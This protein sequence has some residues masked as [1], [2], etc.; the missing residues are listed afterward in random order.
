MVFKLIL[1][2]SVR[3]QIGI[4]HGA[5][6]II[7][8]YPS[9][10]QDYGGYKVK[11][12]LLGVVALSLNLCLHAQE[13]QSLEVL[14]NKIEQH[15]LNDLTSYAE[16]RVLVKADKIDSRLQ[17]GACEDNQLEVFNP[18]Q[19]TTLKTTTFGIKCTNQSNH[20][21][22]YVPIKITVFKPVFV[23]KHP[24]M[25]GVPIM[26]EDVY[27]T[28]LDVQQ[29]KQ[30]FFSNEED[31]LGQVSKQNIAADSPIT[32]ANLELAKLVHKGQQVSIM[33]T[34]ENLSISVQGIALNTGAK[35]DH[36]KV[37][38]LS[39]KRIVDARVLSEEKVEVVL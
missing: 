14:R 36:I 7:A 6:M 22:L 18:Y 21:T 31:F 8:H 11:K 20:W 28:E 37:K 4:I 26:A 38:N 2:C 34:M 33:V 1:Y 30:G 16:G 23:A 17:L 24:I 5:G 19:T 15:V 10:L 3:G 12:V 9:I 32:P 29:L 39:S 25:K 13:L 35:G 27:Q